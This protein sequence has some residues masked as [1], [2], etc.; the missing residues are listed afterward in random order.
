LACGIVIILLTTLLSASRPLP[1]DKVSLEEVLT[2]HLES[3]GPAETRAS[4][5]S[6]IISGTVTSAFRAPRNA[7][8]GGQS[9]MASDGNKS[10]I[11]MQ[12][13]QSGYAQEKFAFDGQDVTIGF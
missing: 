10:F 2:R 5:K 1:S 8:F 6:R 3:I 9:I 4:I 7:N 13:E 11:G 12:F